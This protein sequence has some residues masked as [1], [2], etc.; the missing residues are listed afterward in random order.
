VRA[1]VFVAL[2]MLGCG[3]IEYQQGAATSDGGPAGD[4][5]GG[6]ASAGDASGSDGGASRYSTAVLVD[7]PLAYYR[8][9]EL[10]GTT[11]AD[12]SGN[13]M[14]GV[15]SS[16]G[17]SFTHG[18]AGAIAGD[19]DGA[20]EISGVGTANAS[21]RVPLAVDPWSGDFTVEVWVRPTL[22]PAG[23]YGIFLCEDFLV[24]G[25]RLGWDDTATPIFWTTQAGGSSDVYAT[26]PMIEGAWS[27]VVIT[28][29]G[30][31]VTIY[32]DGAAVGGAD[33]TYVAP[34]LAGS[35]TELG[36]A[37]LH[38]MSSEG[39]FDELAIYGTALPAARIAA[40]YAAGTGR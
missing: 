17:G 18:R 20:I 13:A 11:A 38:G 3:R 8:L 2:A 10:S 40:H 15:Y 12:S 35:S 22:P 14:D 28:K 26:T 5:S 19:A 37:S 25:F 31:T 30:A 24:A 29:A 33:V 23:R 6:D 4:A 27:H 16:G 32:L 1:I 21:V 34:D 7:G 39:Q 9:G 36:L